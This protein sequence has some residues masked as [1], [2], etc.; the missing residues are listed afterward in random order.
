MQA[1][2]IC[3]SGRECRAEL[4][5]SNPFGFNTP[6][7]INY[8]LNLHFGCYQAASIRPECAGIGEHKLVHTPL[9]HLPRR[10]Y[11]A[12]AT[13]FGHQQTIRA[14]S[15]FFQVRCARF[16]ILEHGLLEKFTGHIGCPFSKQCSPIFSKFYSPNIS[17]ATVRTETLV[18]GCS[19]AT[20]GQSADSINSG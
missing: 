3:H 8:I 12:V 6:K 1:I 19:A 13:V 17:Q 15:K 16:T 11:A 20:P 2:R 7:I 14:L 9:T 18:S 5:P 10:L 4:K